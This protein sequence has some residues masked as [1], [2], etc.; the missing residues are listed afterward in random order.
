MPTERR[1]GVCG[2][3]AVASFYP[4]QPLDLFRP[5]VP[6]RFVEGLECLRPKRNGDALLHNQLHTGMYA[7]SY[8]DLKKIY[9]GTGDKARD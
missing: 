8:D 1:W 3:A 5:V 9:A 4:Q 7:M 6:W 2:L